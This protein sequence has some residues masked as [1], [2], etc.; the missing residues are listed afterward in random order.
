VQMPLCRPA[1]AAG[2]AMLRDTLSGN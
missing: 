2:K 1:Q